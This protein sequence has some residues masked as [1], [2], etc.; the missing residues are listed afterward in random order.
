[1][2]IHIYKGKGIIS[3]IIQWQTRSKYSHAAIELPDGDIFEAKEFTSTGFRDSKCPCK[4]EQLQF[5]V[6][7]VDVPIEKELEINEWLYRQ[8]G[9][10]YDYTMVFRFLSRRQETRRSR[11]KWF[12]SE[13][14]FAAFKRV[15]ID[16]LN[17]TE[18]WEVSPGL[19]SKSPLLKKIET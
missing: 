10:K 2:K 17:A 18:P 9:K 7:E 1:M 14:V 15:G 3:K 19:L 11:G 12:C 13:L 8:Q 6:Y 5:D 16:L 4:E